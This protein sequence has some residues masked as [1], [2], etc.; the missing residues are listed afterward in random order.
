MCVQ[1]ARLSRDVCQGRGARPAPLTRP[2]P[3]PRLAIGC[4][5]ATDWHTYVVGAYTHAHALTHT[6]ALPPTSPSLGSCVCACVLVACVSAGGWGCFRLNSDRDWWVCWWWSRW[7]WCVDDGPD[8]YGDV[9]VRW[10]GMH[11]A[12]SIYLCVIDVVFRIDVI[13]LLGIQ[14]IGI[15]FF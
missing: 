8:G 15:V 13:T 2:R 6:R 14:E 11:E 9:C 1:G 5:R 7:V 12:F 4:S 3:R 10:V